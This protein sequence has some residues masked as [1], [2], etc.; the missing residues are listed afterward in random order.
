MVEISKEE[1]E[2]IRELFPYAT[3]SRTMKQYSSRGK[4]YCPPYVEVIEWLKKE[5]SVETIV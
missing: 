1:A 5:R 3:I 4:R 2:A